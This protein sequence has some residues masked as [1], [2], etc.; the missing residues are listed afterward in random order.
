VCSRKVAL[1]GEKLAVGSVVAVV[2]HSTGSSVAVVTASE[3][4]VSAS[5]ATAIASEIEGAAFVLAY[6]AGSSAVACRIG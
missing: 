4:W 6:V 5:G 1:P 2:V 3:H